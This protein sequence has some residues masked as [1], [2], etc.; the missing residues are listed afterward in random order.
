MPFGAHEGDAP[1]A[2]ER[3][4]RL[5][6]SRERDTLAASVALCWPGQRALAVAIVLAA[7]AHAALA[8]EPPIA[9]ENRRCLNCPGSC[10]IAMI[11]QEER[12]GMVA[13]PAREPGTDLQASHFD[14]GLLVRSGHAHLGCV[15]CH[16]GSGDL[17][18]PAR[19]GVLGDLSGCVGYRECRWARGYP[20]KLPTAADR[21]PRGAV[22]GPASFLTNARK[23]GGATRM[24]A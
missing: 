9:R 24:R 7:T 20:S 19:V 12:A 22:L 15:D 18:H 3:P 10:R 6:D 16:A 17:P 4:N 2:E 14:Q 13:A 1:L 8:Q 23:P 21:S 11:S 5:G